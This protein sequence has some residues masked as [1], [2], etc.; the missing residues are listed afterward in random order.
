MSIVNFNQNLI[1]VLYQ[2]DVR[3]GVLQRTPGTK[4]RP[5]EKGQMTTHITKERTTM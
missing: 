5:R 3:L 2:S 1:S 4:Q